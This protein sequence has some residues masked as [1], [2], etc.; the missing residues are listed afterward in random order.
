MSK[1]LQT[2]NKQNKLAMRAGRISTCRS[3]LA[4]VVVEQFIY[5]SHACQNYSKEEIETP[6]V[7]ALREKRIIPGSFATPEAVAHIMTQKFVM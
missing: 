5:Y 1:D 6:F 2:L 3:I 4:Q 7:K